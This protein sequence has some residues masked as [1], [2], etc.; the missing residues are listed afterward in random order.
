MRNVPNNAFEHDTN[1]VDPQ[2]STITKPVTCPE[3]SP[4]DV[5]PRVA[6]LLTSHSTVCFNKDAAPPDFDASGRDGYRH[7]VQ[8]VMDQSEILSLV[9]FAYIFIVPA[10]RFLEQQLVQ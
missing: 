4:L 1:H 10:R 3:V 7:S 8:T 9:S 2:E 6:L 5:R